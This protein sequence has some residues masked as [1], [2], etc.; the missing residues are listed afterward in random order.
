MPFLNAEQTRQLR[1]YL[2]SLSNR[3]P[4]VDL[5]E[6]LEE[7][8]TFATTA[9]SDSISDANAY[10]PTDTVDA[11]FDELGVQIGGDDVGRF[12]F[13]QQ[14][15]CADDDPVYAALDKIDLHLGGDSVVAAGAGVTAAQ[16]APGLQRKRFT[17][18]NVAVALTDEAGVV[19]WGG[20]K[21]AD[22]DDG[23]VLILG[24]IA[25]LAL[26]KS[27]AGVNDDWEGDFAIGTATADNDATL[28]GDEQ[29][30]IPSTATPQ[31]VGGATTARGVSTGTE[32]A[33]GTA[34]AAD[35]FLN[36]LV[37]DADHDVGATPC[38]IIASGTIE[39]LYAALG[40][41]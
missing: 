23:A 31:A 20:V 34:T 14:N 41:Y 13:T 26:T 22:F 19:A 6:L 16:A 7:L 35:L 21:F 25:D 3:P 9:G 17:L 33:D 38:N 39:V 30:V 24:A 40:D 32:T 36:F 37:D 12:T 2:P 18:T 11:A 28:G 27:S 15:V 29:N 8:W 10:Y 5:A 1:D 4:G